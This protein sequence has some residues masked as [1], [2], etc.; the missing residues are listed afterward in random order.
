MQARHDATR[1]IADLRPLQLAVQGIQVHIIQVQQ[2]LQDAAA[3]HHEDGFEEAAKHATSFADRLRDAR[4]V[5]GR[6]PAGAA[7]A[8]LDTELDT[9]AAAFAGYHAL[10]VKMTRIYIDQGIE[11]GNALMEEF[12]AA[13]DALTGKFEAIDQRVEAAMQAAGQQTLGSVEAAEQL[14]VLA[15]RVVNG[16]TVVGVGVCILVIW[17]LRHSLIRPIMASIAAMRDLAQGNLDIT[18]TGL[19]RRDEIGRM[20]EALEVFRVQA[21][22]NRRLAAAQEETRRAADADRRS[23]VTTMAATIESETR[24]A[25]DQIEQRTGAME[26]VANTMTG[27]AARTGASLQG[28]SASATR[29]TANSQAAAS[30]VGQLSAAIQQITAQ[31]GQSSVIVGQA[32]TAGNET[33]AAI[34][35]LDEQVTRIGTVADLIRDIASRTNLLALNA[36]IEAARAGEAGR[37]FAVVAGEV[38]TLA[39]QTTRST[40][41]IARTLAEVGQATATSV[42]AVHRI[43]QTIGEMNA[44]AGAIATAVQEQGLAAN[45]IA[46][47]VTE[48]AAA[49]T[50]MTALIGGVL[51]EAERT[52]HDAAEVHGNAA[53]LAAAVGQLK[54]SVV[55][56]V[57][58]AT[59][60]VDRRLFKRHPVALPARLSLDGRGGTAVE[61]TDISEGGARLRGCAGLRMGQQASID[62]GDVRGLACVIGHV[63]KDGAGVAFRL[64]EAGRTRLR[65]LLQHE[66]GSAAA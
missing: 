65:R 13:A 53:D 49:T 42:A 9:L 3:T 7:L 31:V 17:I 51:A 58:S 6:L 41:E 30:A 50:E 56:V 14:A 47:N 46:R 29:V 59:E 32:V 66:T 15:S 62:I 24:K 4:A 5:L 34:A 54:A 55:R 38:K 25:L 60:D 19:G 12:D 20:A 52:G 1:L 57:R 45:E 16:L 28:A 23:A 35:A 10:G 26:A 39:A 36:T 64:D 33:C 43:E 48:T 2:F 37:G 18:V 8:G 27:S 63:E 22:E 21:S 61:V 44:I 40:E 11:A